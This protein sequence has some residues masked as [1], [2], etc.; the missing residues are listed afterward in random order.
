VSLA[1]PNDHAAGLGYG[2]DTAPYFSMILIYKGGEDWIRTL[3]PEASRCR[4][5][6]APAIVILSDAAMPSPRRSAA[7]PAA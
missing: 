2:E 4:L 5:N 3:P 6:L 7:P 1:E